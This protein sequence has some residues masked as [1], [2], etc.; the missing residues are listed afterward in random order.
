MPPT[1]RDKSQLAVFEQSFGGVSFHLVTAVAALLGFTGHGDHDGSF[2]V[3]LQI[4]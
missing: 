4:A 1:N 2:N 3:L